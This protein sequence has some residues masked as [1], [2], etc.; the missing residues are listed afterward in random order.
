M[1]KKKTTPEPTQQVTHEP[2]NASNATETAS[3]PVL[4]VTSVDIGSISADPA[5]ARKHGDKNLDAIKGSLRRFGQQRPIIVDSKGIIRAGNGTWMAAKALGWK[6]I[7]VIVS[8]LSQSELTAFAIADNRTAE[9]AEWDDAVLKQQLA[10][11][12]AESPD[13]FGAT[14]FTDDELAE[15]LKE[16]EPAEQSSEAEGTGGVGLGQPVVQYAIIFDTPD[17]Q[18]RWFNFLRYLKKRYPEPETLAARLDL[19]LRQVDLT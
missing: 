14:G 2:Q 13:D 19:Y 17:Q 10:D 6:K 5:N 7:A 15:L 3:E 16:E 1:A 12:Q 8:D 9:L 11:L 4:K 18:D